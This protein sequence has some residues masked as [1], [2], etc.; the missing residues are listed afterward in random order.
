MHEKIKRLHAMGRAGYPPEIAK[1]V[2]YLASEDA[3][4][5]TG[6]HLVI[7]GGWTAGKTM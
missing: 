7:D 1:G 6:T 3:S 5:C 2:L 4:F